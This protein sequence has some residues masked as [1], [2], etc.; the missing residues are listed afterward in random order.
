ML[1]RCNLR[2]LNEKLQGVL[3]KNGAVVGRVGGEVRKAQKAARAALPVFHSS[4]SLRKEGGTPSL[5]IMMAMMAMVMMMVVMVIMMA[6]M[7]VMVMVVVV[8]RGKEG[9]LVV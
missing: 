7:V 6:V 1:V 4:Q 3:L 9:V 5:M 8:M 2:S